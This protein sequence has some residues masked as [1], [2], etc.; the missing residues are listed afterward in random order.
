MAPRTAL[1]LLATI[2]TGC[3][4]LGSA[5]NF[6]PEQFDKEPGWIAIR[7]VELILQED[8][9]DC[10]AAA[11]AMALAYWGV[12]TTREEILA[13]CPSTEA[14]I[15]AGTMRDHIKTHGLEAFLFHGDMDVLRKE[16]DRGR[17]VIVGLIKPYVA[18]AISHYAV[19][20]GL[21]PDQKKIVLLDPADG[22]R[23]NTFEGFER[24]WLPTKRLTLVLFRRKSS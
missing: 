2:L 9:T 18:Q 3:S 11:S 8:Q 20:V 10:G 15:R 22:W 12:E 16:L 1:I 24:E 7:D 17:P 23:Q 5:R 21:H 6:D 4:Y 19:I 14:G 13:A